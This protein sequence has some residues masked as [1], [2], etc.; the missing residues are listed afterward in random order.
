MS[1]ST[2]DLALAMFA[3][4]CFGVTIVLQRWVAKEGVTSATALSLRFTIAGLLLLGLLRISGRP[5]LPPPPC[6]G[7]T[8]SASSLA[9]LVVASTLV[10]NSPA[11]TT[12][13]NW[14]L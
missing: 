13:G 11:P 9:F 10:V 7:T 6:V 1:S 3:A 4:F 8:M 12:S 14:R 5:L 2:R